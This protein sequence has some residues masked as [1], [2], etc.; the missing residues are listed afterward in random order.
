MYLRALRFPFSVIEKF[1][2][3]A[4]VCAYTLDFTFFLSTYFY[5]GTDKHDLCC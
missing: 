3:T 4:L 1:L 2:L 5:F